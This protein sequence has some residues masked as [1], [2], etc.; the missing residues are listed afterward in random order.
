MAKVHRAPVTAA[1]PVF[2]DHAGLARGTRIA[3]AR[4]LLPVEALAPGDTV[5]LEPGR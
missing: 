5:L 1:S 2:P 3:T 4:G